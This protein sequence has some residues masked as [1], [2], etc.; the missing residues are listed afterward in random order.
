[1][2]LKLKP[3]VTEDQAARLQGS[4]LALKDTIPG[5]LKAS[6]GKDFISRDKG[7]DIGKRY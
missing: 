2:L 6:V 3:G 5:I 1:V 7:F 4:V